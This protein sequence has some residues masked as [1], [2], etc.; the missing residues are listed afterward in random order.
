[1]YLWND[2]AL[3]GTGI[4]SYDFNL[5]WNPI[6]AGIS[7]VSATVQY[8]TQ[9]APNAT[10]KA[11]Y[12]VIES[13]ETNA[14]GGVPT[15]AEYE[16]AVTLMPTAT[17]PFPLLFNLNAS[18]VTLTFHIDD[19]P[20]WPDNILATFHIHYSSTG[21]FSGGC[22]EPTTPYVELDDG[23]YSYT[24]TQPD[25]HLTATA[26]GP[27]PAPLYEGAPWF[28]ITEGV[29]GASIVINVYLSNITH[30]YGF[31]VELGWDNCYKSTD[32]QSVAIGPAFKLTDYTVEAIANETTVGTEQG[33]L[34]V[35][36]IRPIEKPLVC[37]KDVLAFSITFTTTL[38]PWVVVP[39]NYNCLP[40]SILSA[41]VISAVTLGPN[42][43]TTYVY[44]LDS[45]PW[46]PLVPT[47][48]P[49]YAWYLLR[50]VYSSETLSIA[51]YWRPKQADIDY[52]GVVNVAD[53]AMVAQDYGEPWW[54]PNE[55]GIYCSAY[56]AAFS[57]Q[58]GA[59]GV[60]GDVGLTGVGWNGYVNI[61]DVAFVAKNFGN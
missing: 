57:T 13:A 59:G 27:Y 21:G 39:V 2:I 25:I 6:A 56:N 3:T 28:N 19:E 58:S 42:A 4:Y 49:I 35:E 48:W 50:P 20:C 53:L 5:T 34:Y 33:I 31:F 8:P 18:L 38:D 44:Y 52:D 29:V 46:G 16:L 32:V 61:Y 41:W 17:D 55:L 11:N 60:L 7:F 43:G 45:P 15:D 12:Y 36:V 1:M 23:T 37:G 40:F 51:N 9:P 47:T 30:V 26:P 14:N 10:A 24:S 54:A 22:K